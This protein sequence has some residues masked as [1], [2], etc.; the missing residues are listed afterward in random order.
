MKVTV[1]DRQSIFDMAVQ[2]MGSAEAAFV[3]ARDNNLSLTDELQAGQ[4][5]EWFSI[6]NRQIETY[7]KNRNLHPA[8]A[9]TKEDSKLLGRIFD[10]TFRKTFE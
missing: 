8:T 7:Y 9:L 2:V 4:E 1:L 10:F 5:L 6:D 3:L